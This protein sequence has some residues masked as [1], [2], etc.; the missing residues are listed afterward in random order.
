VPAAF[1]PFEQSGKGVVSLVAGAA[2]F[3]KTVFTIDALGSNLQRQGREQRDNMSIGV[4][5]MIAGNSAIRGKRTIY[6]PSIMD[7]NT[8]SIL[9][10]SFEDSRGEDLVVD[11]TY[12]GWADS[13]CAA[14]LNSAI[15][16]WAAN[17]RSLTVVKSGVAG[18]PPTEVSLSELSAA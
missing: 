6:L 17:H 11:A 3:D 18:A 7:N 14:F 15:D 9:Q 4:L 12:L 13:R 5:N 16:A 10:R 2:R 8:Y 1:V